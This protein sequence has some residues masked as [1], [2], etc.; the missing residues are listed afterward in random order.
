MAKNTCWSHENAGLVPNSTSLT[1]KSSVRQF[2]WIAC[3]M[4]SSDL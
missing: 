1:T 3:V 2:L 4:P